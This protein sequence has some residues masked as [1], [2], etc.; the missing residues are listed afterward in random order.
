MLKIEFPKFKDYK[1]QRVNFIQPKLDGH[2]TKIRK[3]TYKILTLN[4]NNPQN[5]NSIY[6]TTKND[7][8]ITEKLLAIDHIRKELDGLPCDSQIFAELHCPGIPATSVPTMLNNTD[9]RLQ[10]TTFAAPLFN[11]TNH[12][13]SSLDVM[14]RLVQDF[15]LDATYADIISTDFVNEERKIELLEKA[16]E[17]K[18]EGWVLKESHMSGWYKLKPTK[19]IDAVVIGTY[20][21]FSS[22]HYGGLQGIHIMVYESNGKTHDLGHVGSGFSL[23]YRKSFNTQAKRDTLIGKVC[24]VKFDCLAANGKLRFPRMAKDENDQIIWRTDK[25]PKQCTMEQFEE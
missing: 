2:L 6:A 16:K 22:T 5:R 23:P 11:G 19:T 3:R 1:N 21:S 20:R 8:D 7:K 13:I 18:W 24:V 4:P 12:S 14:M 10:L 15:G 17:R 9:E 25:D